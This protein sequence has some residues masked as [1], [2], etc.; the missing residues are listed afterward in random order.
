MTFADLQRYD[1]NN[2]VVCCSTPGQDQV[3]GPPLPFDILCGSPPN[4]CLNSRYLS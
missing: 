3:R 4:P 2:F 1:R